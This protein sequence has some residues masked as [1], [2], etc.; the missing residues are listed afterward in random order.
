MSRPQPLLV[1]LAALAAAAAALPASAAAQARVRG[2]ITDAATGAPLPGAAVRLGEQ[3]G[4]LALNAVTDSAGHYQFSGIRPGAYMIE[5]TT[6]GYEPARSHPLSVRVGAVLDVDL[7]LEP[8]A[9]R[10]DSLPVEAT[11]RRV[12]IRLEGFYQR[13]A[14]GLPGE[15]IT[16]ADIDRRQPSRLS[17]VLTGLPGLSV[18]QRGIQNRRAGCTPELYVDGRRNPDIKPRNFPG[19]LGIVDEI[20]WI[21]P[22]AVEGIEIYRGLAQLP[23]E[24]ADSNSRRCGVIAIWTRAG[25]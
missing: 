5:V 21:H 8:G 1:L 10:L 15:F 24:F 18:T 25:G 19:S 13:Q 20:N 16:R 2:V 7:R 9:L 4:V 23:A 12:S 11:A 14:Q 6:L 3:A 22:S 17:D